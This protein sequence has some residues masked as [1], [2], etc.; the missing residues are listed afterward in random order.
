MRI[1]FCGSGD[2]GVPT[3][4]ALA[5]GGDEIARVFTQPARPAGRGGKITPTPVAS[6]AEELALPTVAAEDINADEHAAAIEALAPDVLLVIDFGRKIGRRVRAAATIGA[7]NLH[8]SL[9]PELRGAAPVHWAIIR[10]YE[11]TGVS[12]IALADRIDAGAIFSRRATDIRPDERADELRRRLADLGVEAV[13]ET[14]AMLAA[15]RQEGDQQDDSIATAAPRLEKSDGLIDFSAD[16][17]VVRNL[18]HGCWPWPGGQT[19]YVAADGKVTGVVIARAAALEAD[20]SKGSPGSIG[21]DFKVACGKGRLE[22]LQI[23]PAGRRLMEWRDFVNG[24]RISTGAR[25][26][27]AF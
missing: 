13:A 26:E 8:G 3:L 5:A 25:F 1:I 20:K 10:G 24:Y 23:K 15:G 16:A 7:I 18:I 11:K 27:T 14:L 21:D 17:V 9:L 19:Q 22:I 6:A 2:F 12:V 4:R